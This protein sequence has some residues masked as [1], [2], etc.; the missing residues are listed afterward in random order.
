MTAVKVVGAK[1][2]RRMIPARAFDFD[3]MAGAVGSND[4][5]WGCSDVIMF[6]ERPAE[7]DSTVVDAFV[8]FFE[9]PFDSPWKQQQ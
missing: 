8:Q 3:T 6:L 5:R 4:P 9:P 7:S 1:H 2:E